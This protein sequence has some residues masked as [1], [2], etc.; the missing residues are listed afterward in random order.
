[1]PLI[2]LLAAPKCCSRSQGHSS[3]GEMKV[4]RALLLALLLCGQPGRG[5]A[6]QEEEDEDEDHRPDDY[7][8]EDEDEVEEEE[9]NRLPG[10]RGRV[11]LWCYAC[12]SLS[13][14]ER[15]NL[16]QS[17]SHGQACTTLIAHG[18]TESGL[19]TT[20]SAWC[21]DSCQPITKTVEGTQVTTTCCQFSLCNVPPWQSSRVQDPPG[22]GAG[23]PRGSCKTVGTALL[24]NLLAGLGA[25][26]AG[27]P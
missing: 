6:Q 12:Q 15:C 23:G 24:L 26:G 11:L 8:E 14:D 16:T 4:L 5:Q 1:M 13:R 19:L 22:K 10:G 25:M 18:N 2:P 3:I 17:C 21:T 9:T 7:D 20:H 27:R